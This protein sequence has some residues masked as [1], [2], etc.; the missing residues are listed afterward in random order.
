MPAAITGRSTPC[1]ASKKYRRKG[2]KAGSLPLRKA[3]ICL[4]DDQLFFRLMTTSAHAPLS[5]KA[6]ITLYSLAIALLS[7]WTLSILATQ[8]LRKDA[9]RLLGSQQF[10]T[11]ATVADQINRELEL[12]LNALQ[13]V[14]PMLAPHM[15][16]G[17]AALQAFLDEHRVLQSLFNGNLFITG[18]DGIRIA[19][20]PFSRERIGTDLNDRDYI[21]K[22]LRQ[23]LSSVGQPIIARPFKTPVV[24]M[25]AP[26]LDAQGRIIGTLSGAIDLS[27]PNFLDQIPDS[28][29]G[30]T[31]GFI[32]IARP[33]RLVVTATEKARIM[34]TL[35]APGVNSA[36]DNFDKGGE[37]SAVYVNSRGVEVLSSAKNIPAAE[38]YLIVTLPTAEAFA[39]LDAMQRF[40]LLATLL[41]TLLVGALT[42]WM[43]RRE[44]RPLHNA[45]HALALQISQQQPFSPLPIERQDEIGQLIDGFNRA[46]DALSQRE[47]ALRESEARYRSLHDASFSGI[48]IHDGGKILEC[49]QAFCE[50]T[51]FAADELVGRDGFMLVAPSSLGKVLQH[52]AS[53]SEQAYEVE[54]LRKDGSRFPLS[55]Q[56]KNIPYKGRTVRVGEF[57]D[58]SERKQAESEINRLA[59]YDQLTGLPNRQLLADR[60]GHALAT[61]FR[62]QREGVVFFIDIDKFKKVNDMHGRA[63][64]DSL[65]LQVARRLSSC[66]RDGDTVARIGADEFVVLLEGLSEN[67][68]GAEKQAASVAEKILATLHKTYQVDN[69]TLN[70]TVCIGVAM[71]D[72]LSEPDELLGRAEL[73]LRQAKVDDSH[74]VRFFDPQ[75]QAMLIAQSTL[76]SD[77][78][79]AILNEEFC[80]HYQAQVDSSGHTLGAEVLVRWNHPQRGFISPA[81][82]I[83]MSEDTGLIIPIGQWVLDT[84]CRQLARWAKRPDMSHLTIAVNVSAR[85]FHHNNFVKHVVDRLER[86][87]ANPHRLKLELTE[88]L[89]L[90]DVEGVISKMNQLKAKGVRF[91]LDDFGTGY[92]SLSYLKR[93]PLD[94]L[95]ID[96]SF[97]QDILSDSN[98]QV[99]ARSIV[100]LGQSLGL[101]VIAEGVETAAQKDFLASK[102][103]QLYQGYHF[104]RPLAL[105]AFELFVLGPEGHA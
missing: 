95:K 50:M 63:G 79:Q 43:A 54:G 55:I 30:E 38:W 27:A 47:I 64:G 51:G 36:L 14:A 60:L 2:E 45:V 97:V 104:C 23:G 10:S 96:Q 99:I 77:L 103:C 34:N 6:R 7:L 24:A 91:S 102:G 94:Q 61:R 56:G 87:G 46:L 40:M 66:V 18:A 31:G 92:S 76:E 32:L 65:L 84:A 82:F 33:Q 59:F 42:G 16:K 58:I 49:N 98:D 28:H 52:V 100:M 13:K 21:D 48:V 85:Q 78:R 89:L 93:L 39:P 20:T 19:C 9:E 57:R 12:R 25:A 67:E 90:D 11:A 105:E 1:P 17:P 8:G 88:G 81:E 5:L 68:G 15:R 41:L 72:S 101:E 35:P 29:Y 69:A 44:L 22:A 80:L 73:A 86:T 75:M 26:I 3:L 62:H 4:F 71:F 70:S 53:G 74:A 37:G 83:P